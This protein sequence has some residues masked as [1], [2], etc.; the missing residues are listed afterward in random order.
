MPR[1][2]FGA[3]CIV[4]ATRNQLAIQA[5]IAF[6]IDV[7]AATILPPAWTIASW[8]AISWAIPSRTNEIEFR[9]LSSTLVPKAAM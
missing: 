6:D 7:A 3:H 8:R 5:D 9:F 2:V 4:S 1:V